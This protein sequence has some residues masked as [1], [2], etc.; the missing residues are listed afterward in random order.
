MGYAH[1]TKWDDDLIKEKIMEVVTKTEIGRMPSRNEIR[2]YFHNDQLT[3]AI[4]K[5]KG[6]ASYAA[7]LGL[8]IKESD[9]YFGKRQ[10]RVALEELVSMG[11]EV[12]QMPQNF[13][14]DLLIND[15]VKV[16]VKAARLYTGPGGSFYSFNLEKP[17]C[18][19]DIYILYLL[20]D[21]NTTKDVLIVPSKFVA[22]NTQ[23]G[24]GVGRSKYHKYSQRWDYIE[25]YSDF[26]EKVV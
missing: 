19:C 18:T 14:Y 2:D 15:C 22:T 4:N 8:K 26:L 25:Q 6:Y 13:P 11:H 12:R 9:T 16:D 7:E 5:R 1:G 10:E 17:F 24:V 23:I 21:D 3:N 20:N